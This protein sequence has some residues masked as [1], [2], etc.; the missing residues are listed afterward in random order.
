MTLWAATR[1]NRG[2]MS[3]K[4]GC[5]TNLEVG[6]PLTGLDV[7]NVTMPN[8]YSYHLQELAFFSW[9]YGAPSIAVNGWWSDNDTF[10]TNA[11]PP[12]R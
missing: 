6:D 1:C 9:F 2:D 8:G 7:P 10:T 12:C 4:G 5:Q 3:D 11:G